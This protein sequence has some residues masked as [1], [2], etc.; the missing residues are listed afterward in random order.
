MFFFFG[1]KQVHLVLRHSPIQFFVHMFTTKK[2]TRHFLTL[3]L[4]A[5]KFKNI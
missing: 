5:K 3:P 1:G 4:T 2:I